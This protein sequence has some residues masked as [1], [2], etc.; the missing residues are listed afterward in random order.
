MAV[1]RTTPRREGKLS[2]KS[3]NP[4]NTLTPAMAD[5]E[6]LPPSYA[7]QELDEIR[8]YHE[9]YPSSQAFQNWEDGSMS[10]DERLLEFKLE[11]LLSQYSEL[12]SKRKNLYPHPDGT[13]LVLPSNTEFKD[14]LQIR[15][16]RSTLVSE[17]L[18]VE[19][20]PQ[21]QL[22][23]DQLRDEIRL[24]WNNT[25][26]SAETVLKLLHYFRSRREI[27]VHKKYRLMLRFVRC[28]TTRSLITR[29]QPVFEK[30]MHAVETEYEEIIKRIERLELLKK[31]GVTAVIELSDLEVYLRFL[32]HHYK[33]TK[34]VHRFFKRIQFMHHTHR[35]EVFQNADHGLMAG[36]ASANEKDSNSAD[37]SAA[38]GSGKRKS[39]T[40]KGDVENTRIPVLSSQESL[41]KMQNDV[42]LSYFNLANAVSDEDG[43]HELSHIVRKTFS[44]VFEKQCGSKAFPAYDSTLLYGEGDDRGGKQQQQLSNKSASSAL[45]ASKSS[46]SFKGST[47]ARAT[48]GAI[49]EGPKVTMNTVHLKPSTW[50]THTSYLPEISESQEK[51]DVFLRT[52]KDIDSDLRVE[53]GFIDSDDA[54][55]VMRRLK[56]MVDSHASRAVGE[57]SGPKTGQSLKDKSSS[58]RSPMAH[59]KGMTTSNKAVPQMEPSQLLSFYFLRHVRTRDFKM[60]LLNTLN[61]FRSIHR[62]LCIDALGF[63]Y[64]KNE[65]VPAE[66]DS[67]SK[68]GGNSAFG[69]DPTLES[70]FYENLPKGANVM[71]YKGISNR[72]DAVVIDEHRD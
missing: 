27:L 24:S 8:R 32:V 3:P 17:I 69:T 26:E 31:E 44:T 12:V 5:G 62:R 4:S 59:S 51:Q 13:Q 68:Q 61:Y 11:G 23:G 48:L 45:D 46:S 70:S 49:P 2:F 6:A 39:A 28:C 72:D 43:G 50:L 66:G 36:A 53:A 52:V 21:L 42:L 60:K 20:P 56:D 29:I 47:T 10:L 58:Q 33:C 63:A 1:M 35:F 25:N 22:R 40:G 34:G 37:T 41:I 9:R 15:N 18:A 65:T 38:A 14:L 54:N 30:R 55:F 71:G 16:D 64:E 19:E 7:E 57:Y 67:P